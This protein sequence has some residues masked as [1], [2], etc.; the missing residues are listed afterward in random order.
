MVE[1]QFQCFSWIWKSLKV[2]FPEI[3]IVVIL[4]PPSRSLRT[5]PSRDVWMT[6]IE[7]LWTL[8]SLFVLI[9]LSLLSLVLYT[10]TYQCTTPKY[11]D[12]PACKIWYGQL[13]VI[14]ACSSLD[15]RRETLGAAIR[16]VSINIYTDLTPAHNADIPIYWSFHRSYTYPTFWGTG[17]CCFL[18]HTWDIFNRIYK[19][20]LCTDV[21]R[22]NAI[23]FHL[24]HR[25]RLGIFRRCLDQATKASMKCT[26]NTTAVQTP[27]PS[28]IFRQSWS[29]LS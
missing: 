13:P 17:L 16:W 5:T 19:D 26:R 2:I 22:R 28:P 25:P 18:P 6:L 15:I 9:E 4:G 12:V 14:E 29:F 24:L 7:Y 10:L 1:A 8:S 20:I 11:L 27:L 3:H 21:R 23:A